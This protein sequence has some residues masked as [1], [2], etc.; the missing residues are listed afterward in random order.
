MNECKHWT[1]NLKKNTCNGWGKAICPNCLQE[2]SYCKVI[3]KKIVVRF[4]IKK[5]LKRLI[6]R[7]NLFLYRILWNNL[8]YVAETLLHGRLYSWRARSFLGLTVFNSTILLRLKYNFFKYWISYLNGRWRF[9]IFSLF[10]TWSQRMFV[11]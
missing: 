11:L 3:I 9:K 2:P 5:N 7:C 1:C 8:Y 10:V 6:T 4:Q